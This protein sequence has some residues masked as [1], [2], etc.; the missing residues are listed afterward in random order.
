VLKGPDGARSAHGL[1]DCFAFLTRCHAKTQVVQGLQPKREHR[2]HVAARARVFANA[3]NEL[4][5]IAVAHG[6]TRCKR[7]F[8]TGRCTFSDSAKGCRHYPCNDAG[9][10]SASTCAL[11]A[12]LK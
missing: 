6:Y 1:P 12:S 11:L 3:A 10:R 8:A 5:K 7:F 2:A 4:E 9:K